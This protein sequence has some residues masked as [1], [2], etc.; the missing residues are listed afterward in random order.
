[1]EWISKDR[2]R[3]DDETYML[4]LMN[5]PSGLARRKG[6]CELT[7]GRRSFGARHGLNSGTGPLCG[8]GRRGD[9]GSAAKATSMLATT[10]DG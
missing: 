5:P 2:L 3:L 4:T 7:F 1:M 6:G 9:F 8:I 10:E